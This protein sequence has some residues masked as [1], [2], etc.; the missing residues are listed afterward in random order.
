MYA[1][2]YHGLSDPF[3]SRMPEITHAAQ[4]NWRECRAL[5]PTY[6]GILR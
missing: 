5:I 6:L 2:L 4:R 1:G 3:F